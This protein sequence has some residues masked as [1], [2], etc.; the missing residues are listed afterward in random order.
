MRFKEIAFCTDFSR[1]AESAFSAALELAEKENAKLWIVHVLPPQINPVTLDA[2]RELSDPSA[3]ALIL[4]LQERMQ[5]EYGDRISD[6]VAYELMVLNGDVSAEILA[7][8]ENR[9]IDLCVL[10]AFGLTGMELAIFG[11]VA[12]RVSHRAP[13]SVMIVR[14]NEEHDSAS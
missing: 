5:Q 9:S 8:L 3:E 2:E 6:T 10:G 1:N 14:H 13:C 7:F 11:S 12:K 4:Q